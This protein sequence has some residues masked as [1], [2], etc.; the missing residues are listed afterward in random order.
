MTVAAA[1]REAL[2]GQATPFRFAIIDGRDG[3]VIYGGRP[4]G[5]VPRSKAIVTTTRK[6]RRA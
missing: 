2:T 3:S 5:A 4:L 1:K 6:A